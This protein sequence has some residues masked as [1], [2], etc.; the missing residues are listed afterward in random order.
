MLVSFYVFE[1]KQ[2]QVEK[3]GYTR[4]QHIRNFFKPEILK[5]KK[6]STLFI[7]IGHVMV[8]NRK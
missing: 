5:H 6:F 3:V 4:S 2:N 1:R 8:E 7:L